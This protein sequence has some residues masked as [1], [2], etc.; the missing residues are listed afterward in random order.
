MQNEV[1]LGNGTLLILGA[2]EETEGSYQCTGHYNYEALNSATY[3]VSLTE[4][5]NKF[6]PHAVNADYVIFLPS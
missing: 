4:G 2:T 3:N 5:T 1:I 6:N